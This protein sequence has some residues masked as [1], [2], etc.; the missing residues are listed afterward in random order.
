MQ[1]IYEVEAI[2][3]SNGFRVARAKDL[4]DTVIFEDETILGFVAV[5]TSA[6]DI[7]AHWRG[8][9]DLFLRKNAPQLRRDPSKAWNTYAIFLT[10][11]PVDQRAWDLLGVESDMH[12]TRKIVRGGIITRADAVQALAPILPLT[13][14]SQGFANL[15]PDR[16]L[17]EKLGPDEYTLFEMMSTPDLDEQG[18]IAWL[19]ERPA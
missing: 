16:A 14:V 5:Y 13:V 17:R 3:R 6:D 2:F 1:L 7:V 9:Q 10:A 19:T 15:S 11:A 8:K 18:V 4:E 12:A